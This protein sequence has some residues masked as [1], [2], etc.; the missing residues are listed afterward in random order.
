MAKIIP[1][2]DNSIF[3]LDIGTRSVIGIVSL[4]ESGVLRVAAQYAVE[5]ESRSMFDGQIHDV[6]KVADTV[7]EVK[8]NLEKKVG[9]NLSKA[10]IAA[11]GRS[12][13]TKQCRVEME[14][15]GG[16][17]ID[18]TLVN[19]LEIAGIKKA[20]SELDPDRAGG[21]ERYYCVGYSVVRYYL[22]NYPIS[23][24]AGHIGSLIGADVL[25]TFLPESVVN[26]LYSVLRRVD[27]EPVNLT[28]EPIAAIEVVIP[29]SVRLL[30]LALIDIG[31]GTSDI[32]ITRK[33][34]V[35]SY[36]MVP[37]AGDEIT[38]AISEA[39]LVGFNEAEKIK[40]A[41]EKGGTVL[42]KDILGIE[43]TTT[44]S[45]VAALIDPVL[46][47]L[48]SEVAQTIISLNGGEPPRTAFCVGGGSRVPG[49]TAKLAG[50]L[51]IE[52]QKVVVRGREAI[53]NLVVDEEGLEGPEGVTVVGIATVA[54]K[55]LGQNFIKVKVD[56]KEFSLFNSK[57][58]TVSSVLSM[59]DF[60]PRD[61]IGQNGR[62]LKFTLN[63]VPQVVY[64][65]LA[66]PAEIYING[67]KANMK[68]PIK[69]GDEI[70]VIK[71][72]EGENARALVQEFVDGAGRK[73]IVIN[74]EQREIRP[75]CFLNGERAPLDIEIKTGD[76]LEMKWTI[77]EIFKDIDSTGAT[78]L[79]NGFKASPDYELKDG[80]D[81]KLLRI[82][83]AHYEN[84][85]VNIQD[86]P[87]QLLSSG[88]TIYVTVNGDKIKMEGKKHYIFVDIFNHIE[89]DRAY[90]KGV[91]VLKLNGAEARYTDMLKDGDIIEIFW[92][93]S[94]E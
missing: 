4:I 31:A 46:D 3:A 33:G 82:G 10:A 28:L 80:D 26:G 49:L 37:F 88:E 54:I 61:L 11:A 90:R 52:P 78:V 23:N 69:E 68:A 25:A 89:F 93:E 91:V 66:K 17:E 58:L 59:V 38:E 30:N 32:A 20:H 44:A 15:D 65:G 50:K 86:N 48:T 73:S 47:K 75:V 36:G 16:V 64:G 74:G 92:D 18:N 22:N 84:E 7:L 62:D 13:V 81:V 39:L 87:V 79:V 72:S 94:K 53:Q 76:Q 77:G 43:N 56:G 2:E 19:S 6:P 9:F 83:T 27:L 85:A 5:H 8:R 34:S 60:N 67:Q 12:L 21:S 24:L 45:E 63:G 41:L 55:K 71:A 35:V 42:Y 57:E 14:I 1:S 40:R 51:G 70:M 29:E